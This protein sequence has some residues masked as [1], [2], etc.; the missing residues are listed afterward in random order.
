MRLQT[1]LALEPRALTFFFFL[2]N[3]SQTY[4][5]LTIFTISKCTVQWH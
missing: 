5:K 1:F 4:I 2:F 3:Y